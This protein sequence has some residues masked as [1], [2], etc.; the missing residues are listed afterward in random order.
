[1]ATFIL[2]FE[3]MHG[4]GNDFIIIHEKYLPPS[5]TEE[6]LAEMLCNRHFSIGADGLIILKQSMN[7]AD[8]AWSYINSDGS[9]GQMCGN[10][11]R[12]F[13]KYLFDRGLT[14]KS[15]FS[16]ETLAGEIIPSIQ[17]DGRIKVNMGKPILKPSEVPVKIDSDKEPTIDYPIEIA[18][19]RFSFTPVSMGNPHA[20]IFINDENIN[21][22]DLGP[23][24]EHHDFFPERTNVEFAKVVNKN[25][26]VLD[27]W[28][29]GCG[30]TLA[31][32]TGACATVIAA[33]L[34][35]LCDANT[36][37]K[38]KLPGGEL[39]IYWD[40]AVSGNVFMTG[41]AESVFIGQVELEV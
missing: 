22:N 3:K 16:V 14:K 9:I 12:C 25:Y 36:D 40:K 18:N 35:G 29:R 39:E 10:G 31:C 37:I 11:I 24:I 13:A 8:F 23:L 28:E 32:G 38:V 5:F 30:I 33:C 15:E 20:I 6:K 2:P 27:V 19:Q 34:K 17:D 1:M 41:P 26:I 4:L 21:L 7:G